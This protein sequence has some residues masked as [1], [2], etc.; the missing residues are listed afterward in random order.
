M[1]LRDIAD[2]LADTAEL[3]APLIAGPQGAA[4]VA[5]AKGLLELGEKAA[6][7][8]DA[9]DAAPL[10]ASLPELQARVTAYADETAK[11]LRG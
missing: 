4:A 1:S 3:L 7:V 8:L 2:K 6:E 5:I 9:D 11:G 10:T